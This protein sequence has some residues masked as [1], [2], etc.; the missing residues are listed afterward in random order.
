MFGCVAKNIL[1]C[2]KSLD[3]IFGSVAKVNQGMN[4]SDRDSAMR[5]PNREVLR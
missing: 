4:P 1:K 3:P 2:G 5:S